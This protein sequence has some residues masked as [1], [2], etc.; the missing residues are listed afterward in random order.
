MFDAFLLM[1]FEPLVMITPKNFRS[2]LENALE[3]TGTKV[4]ANRYLSR[5]FLAFFLGVLLLLLGFFAPQALILAVIPIVSSVVYV[6]YPSYQASILSHKL[7]EVMPSLLLSA[8]SVVQA[9][10]TPEEAFLEVSKKEDP[11]TSVFGRALR[12]SKHHKIELGSALQEI[13]AQYRM[14]ELDRTALLLST[15]ITTGA[16]FNRLLTTAARDILSIRELKK[17]QVEQ[18]QTVKYSLILAGCLL[19][20][21]VLS[22]S[23]KISQFISTP[24]S[25]LQLA[26]QLSFLPLSLVLA[27]MV[28]GFC[29]FQPKRTIIYAP[30][31]LVLML[32]VFQ[33]V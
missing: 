6:L 22:Y 28:A 11:H 1:I 29:D 17:E 15:G 9:G 19:I 14:P 32:G 2:E 23:I 31:F 33:L 5:G 4:S 12:M 21:A 24:S 10:E 18:M 8:A 3:V 20:P 30:V 7:F 27:F 16:H 26:S 25:N 13:I